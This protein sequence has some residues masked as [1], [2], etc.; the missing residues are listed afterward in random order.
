[1]EAAGARFEHPDKWL[2]LIRNAADYNS[3]ARLGARKPAR[4]ASPLQ[5]GFQ[6]RLPQPRRRAPWID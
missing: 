3:A 5:Q 4:E 6:A 2:A 1:M